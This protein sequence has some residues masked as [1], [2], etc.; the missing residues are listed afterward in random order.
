LSNSGR[1]A[2]SRYCSP[3]ALENLTAVRIG[4]NVDG[5]SG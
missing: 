1:I 5:H 2:A 4:V 3:W